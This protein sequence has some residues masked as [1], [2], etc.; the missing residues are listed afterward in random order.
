M[1]RWSHL[2]TDEERLPDGMA[3][4]GYDADSET[5][6]FRDAADGSLWRSAPG[7]QYGKL[8][9]VRPP[10]PL[11]SVTAD[12][13]AE[14]DEPDAVLNE[15]SWEPPEDDG[16]LRKDS[17]VKK[18]I[19]RLSSVRKARSGSVV[20]VDADG[21]VPLGSESEVKADGEGSARDSQEK[22]ATAVDSP[23]SDEK[24]EIASV[25]GKSLESVSVGESATG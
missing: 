9:R 3:R 4:I 17:L 5:Y 13:V 22:S 2:D 23:A 7:C 20:G 16:P 11:G 8:F 12:E 25:P 24:T 14:G 21:E 18:F 19:K 1:G 15:G 10:E 6:T